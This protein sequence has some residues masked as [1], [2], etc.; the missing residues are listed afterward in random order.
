MTLEKVTT[1]I[2]AKAVR[3]A[4]RE[5]AIQITATAQVPTPGWTRPQLQ[6]SIVIAIPNQGIADF[7]FLAESPTVPQ[8]QVLA[9]MDVDQT[10]TSIP[11]DL[12][13]VRL[14]AKTNTVLVKLVEETVLDERA[15]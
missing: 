12:V 10:I 7:D 13:A 14:H 8:P 9:T 15:R 11:A 6:P 4:G 3:I 1:I 2:S 5:L